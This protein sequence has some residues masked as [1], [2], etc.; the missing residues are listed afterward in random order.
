MHIY[1]NNAIFY[2]NEENNRKTVDNVFKLWYYKY[3]HLRE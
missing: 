3:R 2:T 1:V